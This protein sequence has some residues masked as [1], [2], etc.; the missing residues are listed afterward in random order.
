MYCQLFIVL[1]AAV[2]Y[3]LRV[4]HVLPCPLPSEEHDAG[5]T[6]EVTIVLRL[7]LLIEE[8]GCLYS[9]VMFPMMS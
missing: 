4:V 3:K 8:V 9:L 5:C 1:H 2:A 7:C 6:L